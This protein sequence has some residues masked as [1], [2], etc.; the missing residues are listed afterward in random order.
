MQRRIQ[1]EGLIA[2]LFVFLAMDAKS[3]VS[4]VPQCP[5]TVIQK[6]YF[7][8]GIWVPTL[9]DATTSMWKL[10]KAVRSKMTAEQYAVTCFDVAYNHSLGKYN[11]GDIWETARQILGNEY[12]SLL[13]GHLLRIGNIPTF[14]IPST[15]RQQLNVLLRTEGARSLIQGQTIASDVTE[16]VAAYE[17]DIQ[18]GRKIVVVAHSQG[19]LFVNL[20]YESSTLTH[21]TS[22][23]M[24]PV[25]SP[26]T[27]S[28]RSLV[29]HVTFAN[30]LVIDAVQ[31][32]RFA[33][34]LDLALSANDISEA[35]ETASAHEFSENYLTD[36]SSTKFIVD[37]VI[38]SLHDLPIPS[39]ALTTIRVTGVIDSISYN[40]GDIE[41]IFPAPLST[42]VPFTYTVVYDPTLTVKSVQSVPNPTYASYY[43]TSIATSIGSSGQAYAFPAGNGYDFTIFGGPVVHSSL[44]LAS[45]VFFSGTSCSGVNHIEAQADL[46]NG[47][48]GYFFD[49]SPLSVSPIVNVFQHAAMAFSVSAS[50]YPACLSSFDVVSMHITDVSVVTAPP[51]L[52][53]SE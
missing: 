41:S 37:G 49:T 4:E 48:I 13:I 44:H 8:N 52:H 30:D 43:G 3:Q 42:G 25:A 22:F 53:Y 21:K 47:P 1:F 29:G 24:V 35:P 7:G 32:L 45:S 27:K 12:P 51:Q 34:G 20:A 6:V 23:A 39:S 2:F 15:L 31:A 38:T 36:T 50:T 33:S 19:N 10:K 18:L 14:S 40:G 26:D 11:S 16:Q 28:D 17:S 9:A 5:A 46:G